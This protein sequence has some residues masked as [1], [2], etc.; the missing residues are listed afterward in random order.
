MEISRKNVIARRKTR[1]K[2]RYLRAFTCHQVVLRML[3]ARHEGVHQRQKL[4]LAQRVSSAIVVQICPIIARATC[5]LGSSHKKFNTSTNY[6]LKFWIVIGWKT[7]ANFLSQWYRV[8]WWRKFCAETLNN[9]LSSVCN[10]I[11]RPFLHA[12][13]SCLFINK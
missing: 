13:F 9:V 12:N 6:T 4:D 10:M 7:I 8:K 1:S 11:Y 5:L 3:N 2:E